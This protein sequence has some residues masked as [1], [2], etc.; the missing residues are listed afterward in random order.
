MSFWLQSQH[1]RAHPLL[2]GV[3]SLSHPCS[4]FYLSVSKTD[5]NSVERKLNFVLLSGAVSC[6]PSCWSAC[7]TGSSP[8]L[9]CLAEGCVLKSISHRD[10]L[11]YDGGSCVCVCARAGEVWWCVPKS[12]S[13]RLTGCVK[14]LLSQISD[15]FIAKSSDRT[16]F[17][18]RLY[19][20]LDEEN[21]L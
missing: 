12:T 13:A 14:I 6:Q 16:T 7:S 11:V 10:L 19:V 1:I 15:G 18:S 8:P 2:R 4:C 21:T 17:Y 3:Q 20:H 9:S 5:T